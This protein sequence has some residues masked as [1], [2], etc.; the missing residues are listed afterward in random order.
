MTRV[1]AFGDSVSSPESSWDWAGYRGG[2]LGI[3]LSSAAT[4][5]IDGALVGLGI[6]DEDAKHYEGDKAGR[7]IVPVRGGLQR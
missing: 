7:T 6:P 3:L 2:T 4:A 5:G 1:G